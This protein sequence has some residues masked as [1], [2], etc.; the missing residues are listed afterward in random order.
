M[1]FVIGA[2]MPALRRQLDG[3]HTANT[4]VRLMAIVIVRTFPGMRGLGH[5]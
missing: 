5:T 1:L 2:F 3:T 4:A